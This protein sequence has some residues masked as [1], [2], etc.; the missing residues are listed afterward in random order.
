M[1]KSIKTADQIAAEK[2]KQQTEQ[3]I[4]ELKRLLSDSDY[5]VMPD[6]DKPDA[7]IASDRQAWRDEIREL[8]ARIEALEG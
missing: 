6:Y 2:E 3:R 4:A 1:F 8:E 5:K 7:K